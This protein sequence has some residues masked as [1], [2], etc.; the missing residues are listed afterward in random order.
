MTIHEQY[1]ALIEVAAHARLLAAQSEDKEV[2]SNMKNV[3]YNAVLS[4][5]NL[6]FSDAKFE[7]D[8]MVRY[9]ELLRH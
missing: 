9:K 4:A 1:N 2:V 3:K 5:I 7:S 6:G 8:S